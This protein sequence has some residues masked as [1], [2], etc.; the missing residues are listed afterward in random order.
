VARRYNVCSSA[1]HY[2]I[3]VVR[4]NGVPHAGKPM[5]RNVN[6]ATTTV[7]LYG[8]PL[9]P[10]QIFTQVVAERHMKNHRCSG[11]AHAAT[12]L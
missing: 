7:A 3:T 10:L 12:T 1:P 5:Q 8:A 4:Y 11:T 6:A 9:Q 2:A